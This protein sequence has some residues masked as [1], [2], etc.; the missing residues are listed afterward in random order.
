MA[1]GVIFQMQGLRDLTVAL[2]RAGT[3][4]RREVGAY[5][6]QTALTVK[7]LA[8]ARVPRRRGTL[9]NNIAVEGKDLVW[10]VGLID[11]RYEGRGGRNSAHL[12]PSVYG[13]FIE[14]GTRNYPRHPFM[15]PAADEAQR[16]YPTGLQA[17]VSRIE[18]GVAA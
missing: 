8:Q 12:N 13:R 16:R 1:A 14:F 5:N 6:R 9:A 4:A 10:S 18:A 17:I 3:I 2:D 7:A 15:R 11:Q